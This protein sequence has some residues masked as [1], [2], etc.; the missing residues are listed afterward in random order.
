[1]KSI[2][3]IVPR[4]LI[5]KFHLHPEPYGDGAYVVD[6]VNGMVTEVFYCEMGDFVT[7]TNNKEIISYLKTNHMIPRTYFLR[8]GVFSFREKKDCDLELIR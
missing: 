5:K 1:M 7:I 8:N 4:N 2:E 6:L 3:A